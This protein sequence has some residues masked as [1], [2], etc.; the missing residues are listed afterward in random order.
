[1]KDCIF[2]NE[3]KIVM[4]NDLAFVR[5]DNYPVSEGHLEVVTKRHVATFFETTMEEKIAIAQL[6]DKAKEMLDKK[7]KPDGYNIGVNCGE[8][9]GQEIMHVHI[10]LIPRYKGDVQNYRGGVRGIIPGK[11]NY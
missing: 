2:C 7:H 10:H 3:K 1:M 9:A 6:L 11:Q 5:M 4:E 8:F